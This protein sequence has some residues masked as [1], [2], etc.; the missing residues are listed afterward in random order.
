MIVNHDPKS[1]FTIH[2]DE[3]KKD[4][5]A[6]S[7]YPTNHNAAPWKENHNHNDETRSQITMQTKSQ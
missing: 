4:D 7:R 6:A 5:G 2:N 1:Q 3:T